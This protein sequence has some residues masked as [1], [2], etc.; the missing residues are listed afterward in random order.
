MAGENLDSRLKCYVLDKIGF[1][2]Y[3][4]EFGDWTVYF[5]LS[6]QNEIYS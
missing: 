3:R 1:V 5:S 6:V 4:I 2:S